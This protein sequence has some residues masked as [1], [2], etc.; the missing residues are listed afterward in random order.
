MKIFLKVIVAVCALWSAACVAQGYPNRAIRIIV[1]VAAGG[2]VDLIARAIAEPLSKALGQTITVENRPSAASL[3]GTQLVAKAAP[4]GYTLLAHSNTFV[5][6][7][8][9]TANPG[10]DPV[11]DFAPISFTCKIPMV[12]VVTPG[13]PAQ[14]VQ[15]FI[16]QLKA[17]P[18]EIAYAS[19]G[20]GSTGHI[21]AELFSRA[22]GVKMLHVPYKG[23]AQSLVDVMAGQVPMMFDQVSTSVP[24]IQTGK[25]RP[26]AVTTMTRSIVLPN[27]PTLDEAGLKGFDDSTWNGVFAPA[28]TPPKILARLQQEVAKIVWSPELQKRFGERGIE[29]ISSASPD[30]Y[31]TVIRT[32]TARYVKLA[33]E[34][35][36][37]AD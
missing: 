1:P 7:P 13:N 35:N 36:I 10:Y 14:S 19:S 16:A 32:E 9:I 23:N 37:K 24:H 2:N 11:K 21:A 12:L 17:K 31:A 29:M 27:V 25:L 20:N 30:E 18:G 22:A 15:E 33:R 26:L 3:V 5:S 8:A 34:A 6:A 4:D 28:G